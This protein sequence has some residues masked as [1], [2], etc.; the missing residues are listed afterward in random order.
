M[1]AELSLGDQR[2]RFLFLLNS[3]EQ[4]SYD[5]SLTNLKEFRTSLLKVFRPT[6]NIKTYTSDLTK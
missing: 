1:L 5:C 3:V 6:L 4:I 2:K